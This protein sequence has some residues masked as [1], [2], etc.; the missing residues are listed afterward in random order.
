MGVR[1][2]CRGPIGPKKH[3]DG[4][5]TVPKRHRFAEHP[6]LEAFHLLQV[7]GCRKPVRTGT[8]NYYVTIGHSC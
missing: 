2:L 6:D 5:V 3:A 1:D 7:G 4:H 8:Q